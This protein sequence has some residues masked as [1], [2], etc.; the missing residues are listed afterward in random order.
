MKSES[1]EHKGKLIMEEKKIPGKT[2]VFLVL[3][4]YLVYGAFMFWLFCPG[5]CILFITMML[6]PLS[7]LPLF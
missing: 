7:Y 4:G 6:M 3:L 5:S 1:A 2:I